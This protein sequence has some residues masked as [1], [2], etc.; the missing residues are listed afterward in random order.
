MGEKDVVLRLPDRSDDAVSLHD[1]PAPQVYSVRQVA[2]LLGLNLGMTYELV[3]RGE[4]P[5]KRLG[6][7]WL[8]PREAFHAWL[9]DMA[10]AS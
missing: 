10:R 5:A 9:Q 6:R 3:R 4:I 1:I 2:G 7:R 8:V